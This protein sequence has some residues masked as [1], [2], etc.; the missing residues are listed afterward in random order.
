MKRRF[1][2][3]IMFGA[4]VLTLLAARIGGSRA[5][6]AGAVTAPAQVLTPLILSVQ[7]APVPFTGSDGRTHLVYEV[8]ATNFTS[9]AVTVEQVDILGDGRVLQTLDAAGVAG[10]LQPAGQRTSSG[11]MPAAT[12][13]LLFVHVILP[14]GTSVPGILSHRFSVNVHGRKLLEAG[15][16]ST[17]NAKPVAIIGPPL[18]GNNYISAD[19]CCDAT[20]HTRAALPVNGRVWVAQRY[21]VDWEQL[22]DSK[23]IY[24]GARADVT[25]YKIYGAKIF[26]AARATVAFAVDGLPDQVPG[27][28]PE[29]LPLEQADGNH[30][31]LDLGNGNYALYAHMKPGSVKVH[32]GQQVTPGQV[33]GLVGNSGNTIAPHLHFQLMN[34]PLALASNG[35]PYEI[36]AL[37]IIGNSPGTKEFDAAEAD[38]TPLAVTEVSPGHVT[39]ALPLDQLIISFGH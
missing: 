8:F 10:R 22:D 9:V 7:D 14:G 32:A 2:L 16:N 21:A 24:V 30:V 15:G 20:R 34:R 19:S 13:S 25:S 3:W 6:G 1:A 23:R 11:T 12:Q 37:R 26:A 39:N 35:L 31:I 18:R 17:V 36:R 4:V 29:N 5:N 38:G 28:F 27:K 33:L